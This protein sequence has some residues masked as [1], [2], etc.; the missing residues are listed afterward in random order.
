MSKPCVAHATVNS[1]HAS[2]RPAAI[3]RLNG[4]SSGTQSD[5]VNNPGVFAVYFEMNSVSTS[6]AVGDSAK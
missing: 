4:E 1:D 2:M 6:A 5:S 3:K